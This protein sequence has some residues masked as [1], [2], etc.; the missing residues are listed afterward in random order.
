MR[1]Y[2]LAG[3]VAFC[4]VL[5]GCNKTGIT[6]PES[7]DGEPVPI[8]MKTSGLL[9]GSK[10]A[11]DKWTTETI[12]IFGLKRQNDG[13]YD[14]GDSSNILG[15]E[16]SV[17][18]AE[19]FSIELW[20]DPV[21][22]SP[23]F[24]EESQ[25]YDFY[26][27][28]LGGADVINQHML[29][30]T[31]Y[32]DLEIHGHNDVMY[33]MTDPSR[34]IQTAGS[35]DI[36]V[37]NVYSAYAARRNVHPTLVFNH[38]LARFNFIVMG[39]GNKYDSVKI[40][41]LEVK[42]RN[43][44]RLNISG[45]EPGFVVDQAADSVVLSLRNA[46]GELLES[47]YVVENADK[48]PLGGAGACIMAPAGIKSLPVNLRLQKE[49]GS[50]ASYRFVVNASDIRNTSTDTFQPGLYYDIFINIYGPEE[51]NIFSTLQDWQIGGN[52]EIDPDKG[53]D[54]SGSQ[55][56]GSVENG[57]V[58]VGGYDDGGHLGNVIL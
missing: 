20:S 35:S 9:S 37:D 5:S 15:K 6:A 51:I 24:Y 38:T 34:D 21:A 33:A 18:V 50:D 30:R 57:Y 28:H 23:Y 13:L 52:F 32:M 16:A 55:E 4:V 31:I 48:I 44:G 12:N 7:V 47:Q 2:I 53:T 46:D 14:F 42:T 41:G 27:Y 11:V 45:G 49:D 10:A 43:K 25:V 22:R 36:T 19:G 39:L 17:S 40:L 8:M 1:H 26:G 58:N 56:P 29:G 3:F 54:N